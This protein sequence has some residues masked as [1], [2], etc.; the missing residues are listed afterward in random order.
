MAI[1]LKSRPGGRDQA[2]QQFVGLCDE[3]I[4]QRVRAAELSGSNKEVNTK[5]MDDALKM[6]QPYLLGFRAMADLGLVDI[7]P[8]RYVYA[9]TC[10]PVQSQIFTKAYDTTPAGIPKDPSSLAQVQGPRPIIP[11]TRV[12]AARSGDSYIGR[13]Y[14]RT[15]KGWEEDLVPVQD[16]QAHQMIAGAPL[17]VMKA[18]QS[19]LFHGDKDGSP[20]FLTRKATPR[21][22]PNS[23]GRFI[24]GGAYALLARPVGHSPMKS[25]A[26]RDFGGGWEVMQEDFWASESGGI[27]KGSRQQRPKKL[28]LPAPDKEN[29]FYDVL[30]PDGDPMNVSDSVVQD[31]NGMRWKD[32]G[33]LAAFMKSKFCLPDD[34]MGCVTSTTS[35]DLFT[36]K[37]FEETAKYVYNTV[38]KYKE[39]IRN[40]VFRR[41]IEVGE[42]IASGS[43]PPADMTA[44][45]A[46]AARDAFMLS[47]E[48]Q[49]LMK[50]P[51]HHA[52]YEFGSFCKFCDKVEEGG[53]GDT[54][55]PKV[56]AMLEVGMEDP[57]ESLRPKAGKLYGVKLTTTDAEGKPVE[58]WL[59]NPGDEDPML[60][61]SR[62]SPWL[63]Q[64]LQ[65]YQTTTPEA[66]ARIETY[67]DNDVLVQSVKRT[68]NLVQGR[69]KLENMIYAQRG[70]EPPAEPWEDDV[71][72]ALRAE[73]E[74][75]K[76]E[77]LPGTE[78]EPEPEPEQEPLQE[79]KPE[80]PPQPEPQ[81]QP[82]AQ[83]EPIPEPRPQRPTQQTVQTLKMMLTPVFNQLKGVDLQNLQAAPPEVLVKAKRTLDRALNLI[84]MNPELAP[85]LDSA[86]AT[87]G[88]DKLKSYEK[89]IPPAVS[90]TV[91]KLVK[92]ANT[93]DDQGKYDEAEVVDKVIAATM[94]KSS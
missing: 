52:L 85:H 36:T 39:A 33:A 8:K 32:F 31:Q 54:I 23:N 81:P 11:E 40:P 14:V 5:K 21:L 26:G 45:Q 70:E 27:P 90:K 47:Q 13:Q 65:H 58:Q 89:P 68:K 76:E 30:G 60:F 84:Q 64:Y 63:K 2:R 87:L 82:V 20:S 57:R 10:A 83:P 42:G 9:Q 12:S 56:I 15:A 25:G 29:Q 59:K 75:Q 3:Y 46:K 7:N 6:I 35:S 19:A 17:H 61:S 80:Q 24:P 79:I 71:T 38:S 73:E 94:E 16:S 55:S 91:Q 92:L 67:A 22:D 78:P 93:L 1:N 41:M 86:L 88:L 69:E 43:P 4:R 28:A 62:F 77:Q 37:D 66:N 18:E 72:Y 51:E 53:M 49:V 50:D 34:V 74:P 48:A 44:E